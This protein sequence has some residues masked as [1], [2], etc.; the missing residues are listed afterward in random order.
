VHSLQALALLFVLTSL[1]IKKQFNAFGLV[2]FRLISTITAIYTLGYLLGGA[3]HEAFKPLSLLFISLGMLQAIKWAMRYH[4]EA[5][6]KQKMIG[7]T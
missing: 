6:S 3:P 5:E 4:K 1:I 2:L 7:K